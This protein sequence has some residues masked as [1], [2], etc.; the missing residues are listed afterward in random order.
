METSLG[1][2][3]SVGAGIGEGVKVG[4][5]VPGAVEVAVTGH[6]PPATCT[7]A[8]DWQAANRHTNKNPRNQKRMRIIPVIVLRV[9]T[10]VKLV[11]DE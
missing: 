8:G 11:G 1:D 7:S 10:A 2:E 6:V 3:V 4:T 9:S 5:A